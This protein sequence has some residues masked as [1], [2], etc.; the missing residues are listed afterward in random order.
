MDMN[1][2]KKASRAFISSKA[3]TMLTYPSGLHTTMIPESGI[4]FSA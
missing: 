1:P 3:D 4:P 2:A